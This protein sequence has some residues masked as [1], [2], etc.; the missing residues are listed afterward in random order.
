MQGRCRAIQG[1]AEIDDRDV[2]GVGLDEVLCLAACVGAEGVDAHGFQ[3]ARELVD[4]GLGAPAGVRKEEVQAAGS[5]GGGGS[6]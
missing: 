1:E 4:P 3:E 5:G 6:L 2:D